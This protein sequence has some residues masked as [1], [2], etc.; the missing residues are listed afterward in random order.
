M[1][2]AGTL[3]LPRAIGQQIVVS[4]AHE[5]GGHDVEEKA[6][7]KLLGA[8]F[9]HFGCAPRRVVGVAKAHDALADEDEAGIGNRHP[10]GVAAEILQHLLGATPGRFGGDDPRVSGELLSSRIPCGLLGQRGTCTGKDQPLLP[11]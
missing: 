11:A 8:E 6:A 3:F 2:G 10:M 9:H 7:Q 5:A 1:T 4:K